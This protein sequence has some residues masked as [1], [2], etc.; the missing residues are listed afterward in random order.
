MMFALIATDG[1]RNTL[2]YSQRHVT[3]HCTGPAQE[4]A[5]AGEFKPYI[6]PNRS[7]SRSK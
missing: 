6:F 4:A 7:Q 1:K 5:P 2:T 3:L